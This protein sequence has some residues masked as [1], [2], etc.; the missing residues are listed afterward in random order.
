MALEDEVRQASKQFYA[1]LNSTIN[2][3]PG[4]MMEVWS[5]GSD[6]SAMHPFGSRSLGWEEVRA[7]W[8]QAAQAISDRR[9]SDH[10]R[11]VAEEVVVPMGE[12]GAYSVGTERGQAKIGEELVRVDWRVTNIYRREGGDGRWC[13]TTPMSPRRWWKPSGCRRAKKGVLE[14]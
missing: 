7:S 2:G 3:D 13:T 6:A 14:G 4:P 12:D 8:E 11:G 10:Q 1:A 9:V 5:H